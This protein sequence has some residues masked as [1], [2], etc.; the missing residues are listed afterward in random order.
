MDTSA[1]TH[2]CL[3]GHSEIIRSLAPGGV[4]V[5]PA[6][7]CAE[8]EQGRE[9]HQGIPAVSSVNWAELA[10]LDEDEVWTQLIVKGQLGGR[11]REH[12]GECAVIAC[13]HHRDLVAILDDRAAIEQ[14]DRLGVPTHGTM[15]IVIE[16]YKTLYDR[17][18]RR[19]A[20]LVD[21]LL[22]SG[23]YLPVDSGESLLSWAYEEGLLP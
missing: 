10:V 16:A 13:A 21:D 12:L 22:A 11:P 20:R 19:T 3:A 14:A 17:D 8:I 23:M 18:R 15:W 9:R 1:Y 6:D 2:L 5:V 4:V 7:V